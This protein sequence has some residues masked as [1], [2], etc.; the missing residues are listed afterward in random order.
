MKKWELI[1]LLLLCVGAFVVRLYRV[2]NPIGDWHSWRQADT[3]A[4]SRYFVANGFDLL[5]PHFDDLSN[6]PSG[7][8]DNLQGY[9]FV[10]F[11][12]YNV[13]QAGAFLLF[14][15]FTLE[16]WG[17]IMTNLISVVGLV[18]LFLLSRRH[19]NATASLLS[20]FFFAFI[21]F[22]IYYNRVILPDP[23]MVTTT[24]A[25]LYFFDLYV[26]AQTTGKKTLFFFATFLSAAVALLVKP[27]A[28]IFF[29]PMLVLAYEK[30][31]LRLLLK[32]QLYT[33]T[34]IS[35]LPFAAW[36][37]WMLQYPAG[38][39]ASDWLF[40]S[41]HI[42][43]TGAFFYWIFARRIGELMSGYYLLAP[44][45]LGA[46]FL[47]KKRLYFYSYLLASFIYLSI[48]ATGNVQHGYYQLPIIPSIAIFMGIGTSF[49]IHP[50]KSDISRVASISV[51]IICVALGLSFSWYSVRDFFNINNPNIVVAGQAVDQLTPK[52]AKVIALY[53]GD[54]SFLYYTNRQGWASFEKPLRDMINMGAGYIAIVNPTP[55]DFSGFGTQYKVVGSSSAYL[56][57]DI[58]HKK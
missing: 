49:F 20:A 28:L 26:A 23:L 32:W 47:V 57:L 24:L 11:P 29:L 56:I 36:R 30:W 1:I 43:F 2:S 21:P 22:N 9:R 18:F 5:H 44:L 7:T 13:L 54:T 55:N 45:V 41:N 46:A 15:H 8:L 52:N 33:L 37:I 10:E 31:G 14:K 48:V 27:F 51:L 39:P 6:V 12:F 40:N 53:G 19:L 25:A 16:E 35:L 4:V 38:I 34:I 58:V 3:S 42:R 17:R 50:P